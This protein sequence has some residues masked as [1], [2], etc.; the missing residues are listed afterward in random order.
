[1]GYQGGTLSSMLMLMAMVL[2]LSPFD[3][4]FSYPHHPVGI[5]AGQAASN[6]RTKYPIAGR[7]TASTA[8][9]GSAASCSDG[10]CIGSTDTIT[11]QLCDSFNETTVNDP[12]NSRNIHILCDVD[13]LGQDIYPFILAQSFDECHACCNSFNKISNDTKCLGFLFAPER[14]NGTDDCYLKS[15]LHNPT[16]TEIQLIG[17]VLIPSMTSNSLASPLERNS[18]PRNDSPKTESSLSV[19]EFKVLGA[20][21]SRP[22]KYYPSHV[23]YGPTE[24]LYNAASLYTANESLVRD[25]AL[26]DDTGSWT[27]SKLPNP[28]LAEMKSV[29]QISRD[30]GR[31]GSINGTQIFV[32]CDTKSVRIDDTP[33]SGQLVS[34]V[35]SSVATD[36]GVN[37]LSGNPLELV[38]NLGEWQDDVGRMRGFAPMTLGEQSYNTAISGSGYRYAIWPDSSLIP[39]NTSH[40]L[41]Y[42]TLVFDIDKRIEAPVFNEIG[43]SVLLV[44]VDPTYGPV[45]ERTVNQLFKQGQIAFGTVG[46]IRAWG[47]KGIGANDG[48]IYLLGQHKGRVNAGTSGNGVLVARTTPSGINDLSSY[49]YWNGKSWCDTMPS[50]DS[51][52]TI[53]DHL[54]QNMDIFYVPA[55][56]SFIMVYLNIYGDNTFYYR[57]LP[58]DLDVIPGGDYVDN[59]VSGKWSEEKVLAKPGAP[60]REFLYSGGVHG[61]YFGAED[62]TNG[63]WKMLI[64]WT[65]KTGADAYS[66]NAG[67]AHKSAYVRL[68]LD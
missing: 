64:T 1:M 30:G 41:L 36:K 2:I 14:V 39:F 66:P 12:N 44:S 3:L 51:T 28:V 5:V 34:F 58:L 38:D 15:S 21:I 56:R 60:V 33:D 24:M 43:N 48:Y 13:F 6:L 61:G 10:R 32:F 55:L 29:P 8:H 42:P 62:I 54:V 52:A 50:V 49:T 65:E 53:L 67:Y 59:I 46:G 47:P 45:A 16:P 57:H 4:A 68:S 35:S 26:A 25:Y 27:E 9:A 22:P 18:T 11:Y 31:G 37:A 20:S 7:A 40:A 63:G 19:A 23:P 17:A